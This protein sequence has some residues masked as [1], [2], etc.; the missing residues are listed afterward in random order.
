M[1]LRYILVA[2]FRS[3]LIFHPINIL[4]SRAGCCAPTRE[5]GSAEEELFA[6]LQT[7][8]LATRHSWRYRF[9]NRQNVFNSR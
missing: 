6:K 2:H 1:A 7:R 4:I 3:V 9:S 8:S 5:Q